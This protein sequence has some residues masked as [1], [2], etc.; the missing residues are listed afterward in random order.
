M[1]VSTSLIYNTH[2]LVFF[3]LGG[4]PILD[5]QTSGVAANVNSRQI[6]TGSSLFLFIQPW[7]IRTAH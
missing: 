3:I 7:I 1:S 6:F 2:R 4:F 5:R